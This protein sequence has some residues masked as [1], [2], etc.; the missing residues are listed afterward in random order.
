MRV[1]FHAAAAPLGPEPVEGHDTPAADDGPKYATG[2]FFSLRLRTHALAHLTAADQVERK[3][4]H[5]MRA[6]QRLA[7][8][9]LRQG[10]AKGRK[11]LCV[12]DRAGIDFRQWHLWKPTGALYFL[13]RE[14]E[15][16]QLA[17]SG[18]N[19][20][21]RAGPRHAGVLP[22]PGN[23]RLSL[24]GIS[25][26]LQVRFDRVTNAYN[27]SIQ[28]STN[29]NGPWEDQDL[30][31]ASRVTLGGF[32]PGQVYWVRAC[33][34]GSAGASAWAGPISAMVV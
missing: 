7:L 27:Y 21:D 16:M 24:T 3:K 34:N 33:A 31:T 10:A 18:E 23:L 13:S 25:G 1:V 14:K 22:A 11:V 17:P 19:A 26:E 2:H 5:D 15:N 8:T 6:L 9:Q 32:T 20:W 4:E 28:T 29:P 12:W 30:S